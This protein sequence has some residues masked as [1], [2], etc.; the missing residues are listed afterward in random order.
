MKE[1]LNGGNAIIAGGTLREY[2]ALKNLH[3]EDN[4]LFG[5]NEG[6][7]IHDGKVTPLMFGQPEG[8]QNS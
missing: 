4:I 7:I 8:A 2:Q 1:L 6:C 5:K 3:R